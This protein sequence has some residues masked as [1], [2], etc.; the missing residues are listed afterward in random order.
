MSCLFLKGL[1]QKK[2]FKLKLTFLSKEKDLNE[3]LICLLKDLRRN[4]DR[5]LKSNPLFVKKIAQQL[6]RNQ[7]Q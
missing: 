6:F 1:E 4:R 5:L 7:S 3:L 2:R